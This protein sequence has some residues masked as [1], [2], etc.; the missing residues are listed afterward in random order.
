MLSAAEPLSAESIAAS[1]RFV[2]RL[3]EAQPGAANGRAK[4]ARMDISRSGSDIFSFRSRRGGK[5]AR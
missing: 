2:T 3:G 5:R 1:K 4:R